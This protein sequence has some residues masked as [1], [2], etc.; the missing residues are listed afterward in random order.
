M[1]G[2]WNFNE[3]SGT[4]ASDATS[5]SNDGTISGA[6]WSTDVPFGSTSGGSS[7]A[8]NKALIIDTTTPTVS[9]V[10]STS[11]NGA[12]KIGDVITITITFSEAVTV[13]G[14]TQLTLE[15]GTTDAVVDYASGS[16]G[17]TLTFNYTVAAGNASS[18][19]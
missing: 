10:S 2:Y 16:T 3:G 12:Y 14:T 7:L 15:T 4:T 11:D 13:S 8:A 19:L 9:S 1:V 18:D 5:N 17:T 6:T